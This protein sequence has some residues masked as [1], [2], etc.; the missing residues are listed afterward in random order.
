MSKDSA[1]QFNEYA[2]LYDDV[3]GLLSKDIVVPSVL[4]TIGEVEGLSIFDFGCGT[5]V[6]CRFLKERGAGRVVGYDLAEG[7]VNFARRRAEKDALNITFISQLGPD[8]SGQFD[9]VLAVYVMPYATSENELQ[10]M[11]ADMV[12]LLR[13]GGRLVTLPIH[14]SYDPRPSYYEPYGFRLI[15]ENLETPHTNGG[16]VKLQFCKNGEQGAVFAWYWS[17]ASLE[18]AL[19]QAG[20]QSLTWRNLAAPAYAT[21]DKAPKELHAYLQKPHSIII[22][23]VRAG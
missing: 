7:M 23:G 1:A 18:R 21:L 10:A 6:Y 15:A 2:S 12:G 4:R 16:R 11:C 20:L 17:A 5:G 14:P 13:P 19:G 9:L 8:L 22:Q 3:T